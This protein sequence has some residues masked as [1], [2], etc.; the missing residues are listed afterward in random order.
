MFYEEKNSGLTELCRIE[1]GR[2]FTFP[3]HFHDSFELITVTEGEMAVIIEQTEYILTPGKAVLVFPNQAHSL[4]TEVHS[5]HLLCIFSRRVVKAFSRS[6][7]KKLPASALFA[8]DRFYLERLSG[9]AEEESLIRAK[10]LLYSLCAEFDSTAVYREATLCDD[11]LL[12]KIFAFVQDRYS[13]DCSLG[14]LARH[15]SYHP[16][17]LSRYFKQCTGIGYNDH[18]NRYRVNEAIYMLNNTD[19]KMVDIAFECGFNTVRS[20]NR[21]FKDVTEMTPGEYKTQG[22]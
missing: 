14:A 7:S 1:S 6:V 19:A 4:R 9:L 8:P 22:R 15:T 17:Y 3:A 16:V 21:R 12:S 2:D 20:F 18:I 10:G 11:E 13:S 5:A